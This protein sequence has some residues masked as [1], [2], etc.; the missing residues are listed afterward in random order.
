MSVITA[1]DLLT[2]LGEEPWSGFNIDDMVF[3]SSDA[4]TAKRVLNR[5]LRY[6]L[7]L[8]DFPFR[9]KTSNI[10]TDKDTESYKMPDGQISAVY[11]SDTLDV[12]M[13][14]G[15][16][17][18]YDKE[19][20]GKPTGYWIDYKNPVQKIRLYPIPDAVYNYTIDYNQ[21]APVLDY[22]TKKPKFSFENAD[23]Y[24]NM[25]ELLQE[26]FADCL[27]LRA[28]MYNNKDEQDENY[29]PTINE[30][31]EHWREFLR[32]A[33]PAKISNRVVW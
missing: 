10:E 14:I 9:G 8:K 2:K 19:K 32:M 27:V 30:F 22:S 31:N 4:N 15:D 25:P 5:A 7:S 33:K 23:D 21:F 11:N 6:L 3:S 16:S 29:Q 18:G 26:Y 13:F 1:Q 28:I 12:L 20:T 24:I 17:S